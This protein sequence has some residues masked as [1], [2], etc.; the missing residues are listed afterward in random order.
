VNVN[1]RYK[2][3]RD[4]HKDEINLRRR[5]QRAALRSGKNVVVRVR[6]SNVVNPRHKLYRDAHKDELN[7]KRREQRAALKT[8]E[9]AAVLFREAN[10]RYR[11]TYRD[12]MI[13][14]HKRSARCG[15]LPSKLSCGHELLFKWARPVQGDVLWC[16]RCRAECMCL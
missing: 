6:D 2:L 14:Q 1:P 13:R 3:Y 10:K 9:D 4:A 15:L 16:P 5:Q 11:E 8:D 12:K 7:R